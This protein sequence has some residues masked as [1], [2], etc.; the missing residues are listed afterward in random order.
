MTPQKPYLDGLD[1]DA[2][3]VK[4][5]ID[6]M[7]HLGEAF[8]TDG[9]L[10]ALEYYERRG[11]IS[12]AAREQLGGYLRGLSLDDSEKATS[13]PMPMDSAS[14]LASGPFGIHARSLTYVIAIAGVDIDATKVP[15]EVRSR[16]IR[17]EGGVASPDVAGTL[18][19]PDGGTTG[20]AYRS[21]D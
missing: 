15:A 20:S 7:R 14:S 1:P 9:A 13:R 12:T 8:G 2:T 11:W 4:V 21:D 19:S 10:E 17:P 5:V 16:G 18:S 3:R 6:W